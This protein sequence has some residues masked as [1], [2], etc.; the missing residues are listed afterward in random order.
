MNNKLLDV[1]K[2]LFQF[3]ESPSSNIISNIIRYH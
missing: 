3:D 1:T 2:I